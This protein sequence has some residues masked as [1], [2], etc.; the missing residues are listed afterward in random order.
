MQRV[1]EG[2][3]EEIV[4]QGDALKGKRVRVEVLESTSPPQNLLEFLGDWVGAVN[5]PNSVQAAQVEQVVERAIV[6]K[7]A[8]QAQP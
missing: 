6:D 3:W 2:L 7:I 4:A 5:I 8:Q 1:L